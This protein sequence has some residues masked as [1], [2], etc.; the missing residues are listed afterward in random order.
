MLIL[1]QRGVAKN[2]IC[3][4]ESETWWRVEGF[5]LVSPTKT[6]IC[7]SFRKHYGL[8]NLSEQ[9]L[10]LWKV[11]RQKFSFTLVISTD[12]RILR[13]GLGAVTIPAHQSEGWSTFVITPSFSILVSSSFALLFIG[14]GIRLGVVIEKWLSVWL[15]LD[16]IVSVKFFQSVCRHMPPNYL[17]RHRRYFLRYY[18]DKWGHTTTGN[19][20]PRRSLPSACLRSRTRV[21]WGMPAVKTHMAS[22]AGDFCSHIGTV[23]Q[24]SAAYENQAYL[25]TSHPVPRRLCFNSTAKVWLSCVVQQEK[26]VFKFSCKKTWTL[27]QPQKV[28]LLCRS[29]RKV[30]NWSY[31]TTN[32]R[33]SAYHTNPFHQSFV[34]VPSETNNS[35]RHHALSRGILRARSLDLSLKTKTAAYAPTFIVWD[36]HPNF[37]NIG[38]CTVLLVHHTATRGHNETHQAPLICW[39]NWA[40]DNPSS[41]VLIWLTI[42]FKIRSHFC[43]NKSTPSSRTVY[44]QTHQLWKVVSK[45]H[46]FWA[47]T[48]FLRRMKQSSF[49]TCSLNSAPWIY[50]NDRLAA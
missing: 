12:I 19:K 10:N 7:V 50:F 29:L 15:Q 13:F 47:P 33:H 32:T 48:F 31:I 27:I 45:L 35:P 20:K 25:W 37:V 8:F 49:I 22:D 18:S 21:N 34:K 46:A 39:L 38:L 26:V 4:R 6:G 43:A 2:N 5:L 9:G 44:N 16:F 41:D 28:F 14:N 3:Q 11:S 42:L 17:R 23:S 1:N 36:S 24:S 30:A 40:W